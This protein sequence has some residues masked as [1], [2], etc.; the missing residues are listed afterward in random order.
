[1]PARGPSPTLV[2]AALGSAG[3]LLVGWTGLLVPSLIRSIEP[4]FAQTDAGIG[5]FFFVNSIA[6]VGGSMAGGLLTERLGR[7]IVLPVAIGLIAV[8]VTGLGTVPTWTLFLAF[9][10]PFG[11]G[12]GAIDGGTNGLV[13]D[14]YPQSRGRALNLLHLFFSLGALASP[15]VI[16]RVVEAGAAWQSVLI[17]TAL[18]AIPI[19]G[20]LAV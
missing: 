10:I 19:A 2:A 4:A 17:G 5:V 1:M 9:A 7:R 6:Y 3:M 13:L 18:A 15:L 12:A 14:L 8:G 11:F 20:L 16:G